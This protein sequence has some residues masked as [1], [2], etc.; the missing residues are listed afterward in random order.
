MSEYWK[1][2]NVTKQE[3]VHPHNTRNGGNGLKWGEWNYPKSNTMNRIQELFESGEWDPKDDIRALSDYGGCRQ[4]YGK[5]TGDLPPYDEA[6][7]WPDRAR[8]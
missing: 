2:V 8:E 7:D 3:Y 5:S 4:I 6:T 1:P